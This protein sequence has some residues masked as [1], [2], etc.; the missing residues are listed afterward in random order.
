MDQADREHSGA[1]ILNHREA[2]AAGKGICP[3]AGRNQSRDTRMASVIC[4]EW[5]GGLCSGLL[6]SMRVVP[7]NMA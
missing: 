7:R 5:S 2:R 6:T 3:G 1:G 4:Q